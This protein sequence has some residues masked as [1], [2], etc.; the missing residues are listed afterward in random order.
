[1]F[2][3]H[4]IGDPGKIRYTVP[5]TISWASPQDVQLWGDMMNGVPVLIH[6]L[7]GQ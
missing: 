2:K 5:V 3:R 6:S 7:E 4:C 1:M